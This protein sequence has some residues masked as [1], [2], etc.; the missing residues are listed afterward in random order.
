MTTA[1]EVMPDLEAAPPRSFFIPV[2][3]GFVA[4]IGLIQFW[5]GYVLPDPGYSVLM[6]VVAIVFL[7]LIGL[8]VT[9]RALSG[10][11]RRSL[12]RQLAVAIGGCTLMASVWSVEFAMPLSMTLGSGSAM[13]QAR[14]AEMAQW[15]QKVPGSAP[16][17]K[18]LHGHVG[19]LDAPYTVCPDVANGTVEFT[20]GDSLSH[21]I[22]YQLNRQGNGPAMCVRHLEGPWYAQVSGQQNCPM[23]YTMGPGGF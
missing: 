15:N 17:T 7:G 8:A 12:R 2:V 20:K 4:L 10:S 18:F 11:H 1:E 5:L 21:G 6:P 9:W 23:G 22:F 16:C 19:P 13:Q 14:A 3:L